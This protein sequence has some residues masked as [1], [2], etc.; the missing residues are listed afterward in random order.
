MDIKG[1]YQCNSIGPQLRQQLLNTNRNQEHLRHAQKSSLKKK[2]MREVDEY[3]LLDLTQLSKHPQFV[4]FHQASQIIDVHHSWPGSNRLRLHSPM[5]GLIQPQRGGGAETD[6][7][8]DVQPYT[9]PEES[10]AT[11]SAQHASK[12]HHVVVHTLF[13]EPF[14]PIVGAQYVVL[15]ETEDVEG[16]GMMVHARVLNCVDGVNIALLQKAINEQRTFF[17]ERERKQD[18]AAQPTDAT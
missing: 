9:P 17:R 6:E 18:G 11:L 15:G 5:L 7:S 3:M 10:R 1:I 13:V 16:V 2:E 12:E 8:P 4:D 14:N